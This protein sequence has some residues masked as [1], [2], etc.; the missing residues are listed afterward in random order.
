MVNYKLREDSE[1]NQLKLLMEALR[2]SEE[3]YRSI[4]HNNHSP[5]LL[6]DPQSGKIIDANQVAASYYGYTYEELTAKYISEINTLAPEEIKRQLHEAQTEKRSCFVFK[7]RMA[8]GEIRNVEVFSGPVKIKKKTYIFS[9]IHDITKRLRLEQRL[10]DALN[11]KHKIIS[12]SPI[13]IITYKASGRCVMA[14]AA[15]ARI[16][17]ASVEQLMQKNFTTI[18]SWSQYGLLPLAEE[19]LSTGQSERAEIYMVTSFGAEIWLNAHFTPFYSGGEQHLLFMAEDISERKRMESDLRTLATMDALTGI[20]NRR[21]I[22]EIG[23]NEFARCNRYGQPLSLLMLDIDHFKHVNDTYSH[24][25]GDQALRQ[26]A[27]EC[28]ELLRSIDSLGRLGGEEFLV[29]L[30]QTN[31]EDARIAAERLRQ[32]VAEQPIQCDGFAF[33]ITISIGV[34]N[35]CPNDVDIETAIHRADIAMYRAKENGRNRVEF[36]PCPSSTPSQP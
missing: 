34:S 23:N 16:M 13:G 27:A 32:T 20:Y 10:H 35:C 29:I 14:N 3:R 28:N 5:M 18:P 1:L 2:E 11:L 8:S 7:H 6:L 36:E 21:T 30:P 9:I 19:A 33:N 24:A 26:L 31:L 15:A 12:D 22:I 4:F 17:G 25:V